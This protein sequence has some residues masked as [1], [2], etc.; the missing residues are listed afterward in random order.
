MGYF[1]KFIKNDK[2]KSTNFSME[3]FRDMANRSSPNVL[4]F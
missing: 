1:G 2:F 3:F 4:T